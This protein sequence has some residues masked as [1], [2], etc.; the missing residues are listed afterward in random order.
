MAIKIQ[1]PFH[2]HPSAISSDIFVNGLVDGSIFSYYDGEYFLNNKKMI[3]WG[4]YNV[5]KLIPSKKDMDEYPRGA[6]WLRER[7]KWVYIGPFIVQ[8]TTSVGI[9]YMTI[10]EDFIIS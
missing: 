3:P 2:I 5:K 7:G 6:T 1:S 4:T 8:Q 9:G 10:G